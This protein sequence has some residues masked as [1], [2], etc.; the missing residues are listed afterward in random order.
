[1]NTVELTGVVMLGA[2]SA[3]IGVAD[4][5]RAA[6]TEDGLSD[7]EARKRF[8]IVDKDGL[9]HSGRTELTR[10]QQ[11]YAQPA[12]RVADW[13]R[14]GKGQIG[15]ADV[16][17][18]IDATIL[19]GLSTAGGAFTEAIVRE[20]ARKVRRPIIFPL[21]NPTVK[22]EATADDLLR[23]TEGRALVATGS[24]FAPVSYG[25]RRIPIAQCNNIYIFPAIGLG[26]VASGA[27]RVTD[28]MIL[29]AARA[30]AEN[31]P[32]LHDAS[33]SLLP[34]LADLRQVAAH[35]A[36]AVGLE[37]QRAGVAPK[38]TEEKLCQRV[39]ATQ[40]TPAYP[41]FVTSQK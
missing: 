19:I 40:W 13:P 12:E 41:A 15:L 16:I 28:A 20:M 36:T 9:L 32:A 39:M 6:M 5:L 24:P 8:W 31:S 33:A 38:T 22:S 21:S 7:Q 30:L 11:V 18:N 17:R 25:G 2:G 14:T 29:T 26:V 23:W 35:I 1:V 10:E 27:R 37:A 34:A 4:F 3:G